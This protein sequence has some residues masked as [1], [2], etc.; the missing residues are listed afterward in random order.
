[1][2]T[3]LARRAF[4]VASGCAKSSLL[5]EH[6]AVPGGH[7]QVS[8]C[9]IQAKTG[10]PKTSGGTPHCVAQKGHFNQTVNTQA[11]WTGCPRPLPCS[12]KFTV[13]LK[14]QETGGALCTAVAPAIL[15]VLFCRRHGFSHSRCQGEAHVSTSANERRAFQISHFRLAF[16]TARG[17]PNSEVLISLFTTELLG[18]E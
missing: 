6:L 9:G 14:M 2:Q 16:L 3:C 11:K 5:A 1:M 18:I 17:D 10:C 13:V 7:W 4:G 15:L 8:H 12:P